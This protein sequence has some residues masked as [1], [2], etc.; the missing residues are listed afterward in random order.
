MLSIELFKKL[1][2]ETSNIDIDKSYARFDTNTLNLIIELYLKKDTVLVCDSCHSSDIFIKGP[3]ITKIKKT[4]LMPSFRQKFSDRIL[5]F[6]SKP[7]I[8]Q[9]FLFF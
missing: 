3:K 1:N 9:F 5:V 6:S 4:I 7:S 8:P 2:I